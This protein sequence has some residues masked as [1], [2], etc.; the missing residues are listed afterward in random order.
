MIVKF[1]KTIF[2]FLVIFLVAAAAISLH[3]YFPGIFSNIQRRNTANEGIIWG[4][5]FSQA[6]AEYFKLD[7]R[8]TYKAMID[9][10][11]VKNIKIHTAW[12]K[13][14]VKKDKYF[15]AD[16]DW[17]IKQ[18]QEKNV[19]IIYVVGL[20]TGRWPECH[21]PGWAQN[22]PQ[23]Q[24]QAEL[25]EYLTAV[26]LRYKNSK[27]IINWQVENEPLFR[28]G[29][30]P[31]WYYKN[32]KFLKTEVNLV[33]SLDSR[34]IIVSDSGEQSTWFSA[35]KVGDIVGIT[36]Y[37]NAWVGLADTFGFNF[38]SFLNP[39][40]YRNK[41][42]V[43]KNEFGKDVVCIELQAEPWASEP[44]LDAPME[45]Q[46]KSMNP[47]MFKENI[48]FAKETGLGAFYFWGVEWWYWMKESQ[49]N[50]QI[51]DEAKNLFTTQD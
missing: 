30:C 43:I 17:Q 48:Q 40:V 34:P 12:D 18:A 15:F 37:R 4:V 16:I 36:M 33:K 49:N 38:Y 19:K 26:V 14:E 7:W 39:A 27:A 10:L 47:E 50:P 35:A 6:Q 46:L 42:E 20:K 31:A 45:E 1:L 8:K 9:E 24:Q 28:F 21:I 23:E 5:A 51:W 2:L 13:I 25:L 22:L 44:L 11:G 29:E 3:Y 41:A 32:D